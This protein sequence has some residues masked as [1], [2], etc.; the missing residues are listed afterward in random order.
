M[1]TFLRCLYFKLSVDGQFNLDSAAKLAKVNATYKVDQATMD[2]G[3]QGGDESNLLVNGSVV[4]G[5]KG[6]LGD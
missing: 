6:F 1:P 4:G 2:L 3:F 5:Y